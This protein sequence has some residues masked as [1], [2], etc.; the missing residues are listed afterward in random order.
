MPQFGSGII[1]SGQLGTELSYITRRGFVPKC[2]V[3][4]YQ[5]SPTNAILFS[6]AN[7]ASGGVSP[8]TVPVQGVAMT[9]G[10]W[11][12][13]SGSFPSPQVIP[14]IY[15]AEFN[16]KALVVPVA[17]LGM[18]ALVQVNE[19]VIDRLEA[20][21]NDASNNAIDLLSTALFG[22]TTNN[23]A[24]IGLPGAVD[25]GSTLATY[26]GITRNTS[27]SENVWWESKVMVQGGTH[28]PTRDSVLLDIINVTT[29]SGGER[30][31][32]G[33]SG[34]LTWHAL[35]TDFVANERYL[36]AADG[37]YAD[38]TFGARAA[39]QALMVGGVPIYFDPY[40]TTEG[41]IYYLNE[42]YLSYYIHQDVSF[43]FTGFESV[44][45]NSQIGYVGAL[46][47]LLE[48]VNAKPKSCGVATNYAYS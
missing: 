41:T 20:T 18:Q 23:Q 36:I 38:N 30:P 29:A 42:N 46:L 48:L 19:T 11:T 35:A 8:V 39:F 3:Q 21:M 12:D 13:Y 43:G 7:A 27:S 2:I 45:P 26:G 5:A 32:F 10:G 22:N 24:I 17:L 25:D 16:L 14:G 15:N 4:I 47:S 28:A 31:T 37:S 1:P 6:H 33:I 40:L 34:P 9:Q 44:L